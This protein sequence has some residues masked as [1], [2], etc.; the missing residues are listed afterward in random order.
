M[1]KQSTFHAS[2]K[3]IDREWHTVDASDKILGR[4]AVNVA[5]LLQGKHKPVISPGLDMGDF[6][7]V[8]NT[9]KI[10]V[11]GDKAESKNYYRHS[12]YPGGLKSRTFNEQ[13]EKD[14]TKVLMLAVK[15]MLPKNRLG[16]Q[17]FRKLKCYAGAEHPH[18]AQVNQKGENE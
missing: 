7:V 18:E 2:G 3:D 1:K 15:G 14:S 10:L 13:M 5:S 9:D 6:V 17:M 4:L 12:Q 8:L 16:R 11:S